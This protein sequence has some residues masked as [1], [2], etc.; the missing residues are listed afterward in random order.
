MNAD[1]LD[2]DILIHSFLRQ[3]I[4]LEYIY[5]AVLVEG[6]MLLMLDFVIGVA[7][8]FVKTSNSTITSCI[9]VI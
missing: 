6:S 5:C 8:R 9:G 2:M 7:K 1:S 4:N 3:P